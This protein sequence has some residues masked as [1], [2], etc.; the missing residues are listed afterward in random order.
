[1][2]HT[3]SRHAI[4]IASRSSQR[5]PTA[6]LS[7]NGSIA[8][9]K[10]NYR[11]EEPRTGLPLEDLFGLRDNSHRVYSAGVDLVPAERVTLGGSYS[12]ERYNALSRSRQAT[13][14]VEQFD[15]PRRNWAAEGTD[16]VHSIIVSGSIT[17]IAE[18]FDL[19]LSYDF[20][21][22][23]AIYEYIAGGVPDRTLPEESTVQPDLGTPTALPPVKGDLGRGSADLIYNLTPRVGLGMSYWYEQYRVADFTLDAEANPVLVRGQAMLLG[24]LYRPYTANTF[25]GRL[26]VRW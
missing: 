25:W 14:A 12:Y 19:L 10:D 3:T 23:R 11:L 9:G 21:R 20:N 17:Q 2:R 15:N 1:M 13:R 24:Y 26:I 8:A 5:S 16:R 22:A 6:T 18:K 4:A 7:L